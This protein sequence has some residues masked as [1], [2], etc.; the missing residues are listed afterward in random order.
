M[1]T[2]RNTLRPA[3]IVLLSLWSVSIL[4]LQLFKG[5]S[6]G[7]AACYTDPTCGENPNMGYAVWAA[8]LAGVLIIL[9][10]GDVWR[11]LHKKARR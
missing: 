10:V 1:D 8:W 2:V 11:R 6:V 4:L 9:A 3:V 7:G 5:G